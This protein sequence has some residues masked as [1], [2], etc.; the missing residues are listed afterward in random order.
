MSI[1][2]VVKLKPEVKKLTLNTSLVNVVSSGSSPGLKLRN[3]CLSFVCSKSYL[4][5]YL[6]QTVSSSPGINFNGVLA[7]WRNKT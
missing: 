1:M 3:S 5:S 7:P 6:F 4:S 2:K